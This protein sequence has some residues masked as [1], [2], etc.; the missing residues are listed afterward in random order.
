MIPAREGTS[1]VIQSGWQAALTHGYALQNPIRYS[2]PFGLDVFIC[3][4]PISISWVPQWA[5]NAVIP[6]H[7]W[8]KTDTKEAG[9]GGE[10]PVL[11]QGSSDVPYVTDTIVKDHSDQSEQ[12][13]ASCQKMN[14]VDERCVNSKLE[15]GKKLGTWTPF[16]QCQAYACSVVTKCRTGSQ[17]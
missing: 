4:R 17:L 13:G 14:N 9:M 1:P 11:G 6:D 16:N 15:L 12:E 2:D 10:Y 5:S 3:S 8:V 7:T